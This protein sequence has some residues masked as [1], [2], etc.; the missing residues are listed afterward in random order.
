MRGPRRAIPE[1]RTARAP[2]RAAH[3]P[4]GSGR[5]LWCGGATT[6]GGTASASRARCSTR[7]GGGWGTVGWGSYHRR[8]D[9]LRFE[10]EVLDAAGGTVLHALEPVTAAA[11]D[12]TGAVELLRQRV[13]AGFAVLFGPAFEAGQAQTRPPAYEAYQEVLAGDYWLSRYSYPDAL[14]HYRRAIALD[15]GYTDART[16][17]AEVLAL[18]G[19]CRAVDSTA[20]S[21]DPM[22]TRLPPVDRGH[23]DWARGTWRGGWSRGPGRAAPGL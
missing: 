7:Q 14:A 23:L 4:S 17:A 9:S 1:P 8:G 5:A 18:A 15:S 22:L 20:A 21:L 3:W 11:G 10:G 19:N 12:E 6:A 2:P 16:R 13:M